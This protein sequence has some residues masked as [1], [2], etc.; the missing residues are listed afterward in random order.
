MLHRQPTIEELRA[1]LEATR[2][3]PEEGFARMVAWGLVNSKGQLTKLF[4]GDADPE[5]GAQRPTER[6]AANANGK[7]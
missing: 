7:N 1:A 6:L 5:P 4:G 2:L 3:P